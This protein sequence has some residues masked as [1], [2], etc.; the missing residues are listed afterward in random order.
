M[1]RAHPQATHPA[2]SQ[3]PAGPALLMGWRQ[4]LPCAASSVRSRPG[5][6][7]G[8]EDGGLRDPILDSASCRV[9]FEG[10]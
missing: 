2:V 1:M 9:S 3:P 6:F 10:L 8:F 7:R 5:H 4:A